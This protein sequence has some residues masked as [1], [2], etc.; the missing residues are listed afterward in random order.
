MLVFVMSELV[1]QFISATESEDASLA[2]RLAK[3]SDDDNLHA[4]LA[5]FD[6]DGSGSLSDDQR[7]TA[8]RVLTKMHTPSAKGLDRLH[9]VLAYLDVNENKKL[10]HTEVMMAVEILELFCKADSVNDS[11][12]A[13]ELDMLLAAL[14]K[15]DDNGNG[16][17][18][19]AER[20]ALRDGLW[21]PDEFLAKLLD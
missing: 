2:K 5:C 20:T 16:V 12:S 11:L 8:R 9:Q 18:D 3:V 21:T 4:I 17:L 1:D 7:S 6:W 15:L 14:G 13:K 19:K 10:E